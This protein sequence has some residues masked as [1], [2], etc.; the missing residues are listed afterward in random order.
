M[1]VPNGPLDDEALYRRGLA[2]QLR[3]CEAIARGARGA[4]MLRAPGVTAGVFPHEPE[5]SI[6][7][8][9]V[10]EHGLGPAERTAAL[11]AMEAAYASAAIDRFAAWTHESDEAMR[12]ALAARGYR[13]VEATRAM[14]MALSELNVPRPELD[15]AF[16]DWPEYVR[17]MHEHGAP[18][19]LYAG[20]DPAGFQVLLAR[21]GDE[22]PA[23]ALGFAHESDYGIYN[24]STLEHA[25]RRGLATALTARLLHDAAARGYRTATLQSTEMA[26]RVYAAVGFRDLGRILE[27]SR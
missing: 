14:G 21:R 6:Y 15:F 9:A 24:V 4:A 27:F 22:C 11:D 13:L 10:L 26:E 25:R 20:V 5:R 17:R 8:N 19:G 7:N 1:T 12:A 23:M 3:C 2:T 16:G 18:A